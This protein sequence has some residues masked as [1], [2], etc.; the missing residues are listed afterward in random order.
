MKRRAVLLGASNLTRGLAAVLGGLI[1]LWPEATL[2]VL[3]ALGHGRSYGL[4]S[5]VLGRSLP[6]ILHCRLWQALAESEPAPTTALITDIGNDLLY[7][8]APERIGDWVGEA[9]SRLKEA[10]AEITVTGLPLD[11][12]RSLSRRRFVVFRSLFFPFSRLVFEDAVSRA[13]ALDEQVRAQAARH[14]ARV[15]TQ[16]SEWYGLDPIHFR[17]TRAG[18]AWR[19]ALA[20]TGGDEAP[21][22]RTDLLR[23]VWL[24]TRRPRQMRLFG[25]PAGRRQPCARLPQGGTLSLF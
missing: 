24:R 25:L 17:F 10:G 4:T 22:F 20:P 21:L 2:D 5:C 13:V 8:V 7:G 6:G 12:V 11:S 18:D 16:Q 14:G 3:A 1:D 15:V 19:A 9:M 23:W